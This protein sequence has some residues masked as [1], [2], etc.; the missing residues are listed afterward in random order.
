MIE[1]APKQGKKRRFKLFFPLIFLV[2]SLSLPLIFDPGL[3]KYLWL[4]HRREMIKREVAEEIERGGLGKEKLVVLEFSLDEVKTKLKWRSAREFEYNHELYDVVESALD[5]EK[6]LFWCWRD[7][8]ETKIEKEIKEVIANSFKSKGK[9]LNSQ[10]RS[11][12]T[13]RIYLFFPSGRLLLARP[14]LFSFL[15]ISSFQAIYSFNHQPPSP[16]PRWLT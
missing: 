1:K 10:E 4:E 16:P 3:G 15:Y 14:N 6:I 5:Q 11:N 8:Q 12:S 13:P 7:Q 2:A 9:S